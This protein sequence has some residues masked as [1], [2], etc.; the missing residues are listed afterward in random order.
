M[1]NNTPSLA[2]MAERMNRLRN[3][4]H[5]Q[6]VII[7]DE[8]ERGARMNQ[9]AIFSAQNRVA[10]QIHL[11]RQFIPQFDAAY[12]AAACETETDG[13]SRQIR[14]TDWLA[15]SAEVGHMRN[16]AN[17]WSTIQEKIAAQCPPRR[18]SLDIKPDK[19]AQRRAVGDASD[20]VAV[21]LQ[22]VLNPHRL[23]PS[24]AKAGYAS[25]TG[26]PQSEFLALLLGAWRLLKAQGRHEKTRFLDVGCGGG[27]RVLS[28]L[29]FF[30][31]AYGLERDPG[32]ANAARDLFQRDNQGK[33]E[34][35]EGDARDFASYDAFDVIHMCRPMRSNRDL[36]NLE[37]H[38]IASSRPQ[39]LVIIDHS[40]FNSRA[41]S[42][43][44]ARVA[45][46]IYLT[47]STS[48][49]A[50]SLRRKAELVGTNLAPERP[51]LR[52]IWEPILAASKRRGY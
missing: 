1:P 42:L 52:S 21:R 8:L 6:C 48:R 44:C 14:P 26:L 34:V 4:I 49:M 18:R 11:L 16:W 43:G 19:A 13:I 10:H 3:D 5:T 39:S 51:A 12:H 25:E 22:S 7:A 47:A 2:Q 24:T 32:Y 17:G 45:S 29:E 30:D 20:R 27:L 33:A 46:R 35:L 23:A 41:N 36:H 38:V 31:E 37:D 40:G 9:Q 28:A 15:F 50:S